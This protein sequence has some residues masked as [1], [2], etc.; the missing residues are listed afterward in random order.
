MLTSLHH[1]H[2][3]PPLPNPLRC[4]P[5]LPL[6][7]FDVRLDLPD[8]R[9][10]LLVVFIL[11]LIQASPLTRGLGV[12]VGFG[13]RER[14]EEARAADRKVEREDG[15]IEPLWLWLRHGSGGGGK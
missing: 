9:E 5:D 8:G 11:A 13:V 3:P 15:G 2:R 6:L 7:F 4:V 1:P 14:G 12:R 10:I